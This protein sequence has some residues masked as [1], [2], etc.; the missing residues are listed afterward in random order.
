ML[1]MQPTPDAEPLPVRPGSMADGSGALI[2]ES[3]AEVLKGVLQNIFTRLDD[4]DSNPAQERSKALG[5][6]YL[7]AVGLSDTV[8]EHIIHTTIT[9]LDMMEALGRFN[10]H[11]R[12]KLKLHIGISTAGTATGVRLASLANAKGKRNKLRLFNDL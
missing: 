7:A 4:L 5:D 9:A 3:N 8:A 11:T 10:A 6:A 12:Y 1:M 2:T